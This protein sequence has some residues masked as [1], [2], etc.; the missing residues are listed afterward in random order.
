[1]NS[2]ASPTDTSKTSV[3][4]VCGALVD[5]QLADETYLYNRQIYRFCGSDCRR[6]FADDPDTYIG[7]GPSNSKGRLRRWLDRLAAVNRKTLGNK[8]SCCH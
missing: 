6:Q 7:Q 8:R 2:Q 5:Q 3:D 4:P 1:M